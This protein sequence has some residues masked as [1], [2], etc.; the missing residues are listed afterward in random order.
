MRIAGTVAGVLVALI[1]LVWTLQGLNSTLV[2]QSFMTG[3]GTWVVIGLITLV[4]GSVL[5]AWSWRRA[6]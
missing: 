2:P 4:L 5:A 3:T 1:G 6:S